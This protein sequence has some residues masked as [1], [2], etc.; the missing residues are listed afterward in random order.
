[1]SEINASF[2]EKLSN[3]IYSKPFWVVLYISG[4]II[5][6]L[7]SMPWPLRLSSVI[8]IVALL[9]FLDTAPKDWK[10]WMII[11]LFGLFL[12]A[13]SGVINF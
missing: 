2:G 7:F 8:G 5:S 12:A 6:Y 11:H 1:M 3:V 9:K 13:A 4:A 10:D